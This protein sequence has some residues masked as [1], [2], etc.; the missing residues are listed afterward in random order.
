M[1]VR[2]VLILLNELVLIG[3][4]LIALYEEAKRRQWITE[5]KRL[6]ES[7]KDARTDSDRAD[8]A[9]RLFEHR[10]RE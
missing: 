7:L 9:R 6:S 2:G 1:T 4:K 5:G 10:L 3:V 8:L